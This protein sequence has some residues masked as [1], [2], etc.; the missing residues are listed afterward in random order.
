MKRKIIQIANSTQLVS[1]PRKWCLANNIKKGD[2]IDVDEQGA[3]VIVS[4][5]KKKV[6][7][8]IEL[9]ITG[10]DRTSLFY[11]IRALY[12]K[13]YD[14]IKVKFDKPTTKHFRKNK[15]LN[16]ITLIHEEATRLPGM[17][18]IQ[19]KENFCLLKAISDA[20]S[21][22]L[23]VILKRIFNLFMDAY[24]DLIEGAKKKNRT[25]LETIRE[26]H[27]TITKFISHSQR[28]LNKNVTINK[29]NYSLLYILAQLDV[30][31]DM[32]NVSARNIIHYNKLISKPTVEILQ[33]L[34][35][36]FEMYA[37][38]FQKFDKKL[39]IE[40]SKNK[41]KVDT[42]IVTIGKKLPFEEMHLILT[43]QGSLNI[44]RCLTESSFAMHY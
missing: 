30:I 6:P 24:S 27:D 21:S 3:Q 44:L 22:E 17:E 31:T 9:D 32:L 43:M 4:S 33:G 42:N 2:E 1:L 7:T 29:D 11:V 15:E 38:L 5:E 20:Q 14:E 39:I 16:M 23:Q 28:L 37:T 19:Q 36:S 35:K 12:K 8:F 18:V 40:I 26:K 25:L 10:L 34:Y 41:V 13:G